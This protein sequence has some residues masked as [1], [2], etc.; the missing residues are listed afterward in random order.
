MDIEPKSREGVAVRAKRA[1]TPVKARPPAGARPTWARQETKPQ[2]AKVPAVTI[3]PI[4]LKPASVAA[5]PPQAAVPNPAAERESK[6]FLEKV[7]A[8]E[9]DYEAKIF[10][11]ERDL[12]GA[13][14]DITR[15]G[16]VNLWLRVAAVVVVSV[17]VSG[18]CFFAA[19]RGFSATP[20]VSE[21]HGET[22]RKLAPPAGDAADSEAAEPS[23]AAPERSALK[24]SMR[25]AALSGNAG[26]F[27][28]AALRL[29]TAVSAFPEKQPE[30]VIR[31][32]NEQGAAGEPVCPFTWDAS[33]AAVFQF[34]AAKR[35]IP[36]VSSL[37]E[38][39]TTIEKMHLH[40]TAPGRKAVR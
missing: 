26:P 27:T 36:I 8:A 1:A 10:S 24:D 25:A 13:K 6:A 19:A 34:G 5:A 29:A 15:L 22:S 16:K 37:D 11:L 9:A 28:K 12:G 17:A 23:S 32:A 31:E 18:L 35:P 40:A 33:G 3:T 14:D 38:C 20:R 39:A 2:P 21:A 4:K 7:K 30:D